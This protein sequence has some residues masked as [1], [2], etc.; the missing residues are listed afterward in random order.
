MNIS[1]A[2]YCT[3]KHAVICINQ[4]MKSEYMQLIS[5]VRNIMPHFMYLHGVIPFNKYFPY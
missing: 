2:Y 3:Y 5:L 1:I 4:K